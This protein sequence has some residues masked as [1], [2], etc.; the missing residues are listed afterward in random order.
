MS[1]APATAARIEAAD[2]EAVERITGSRPMLV[3]FGRALDVVPGMTPTTILH[4]GPPITWLA[5]GEG[6]GHTYDALDPQ[7]GIDYVLASPGIDAHRARV[8]STRA[9][10]HLPVSVDS[11][12]P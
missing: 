8:L 4:A 10:D 7:V 1:A 11:T 9:S 6:A 12:L 3:G 2:V 5:A